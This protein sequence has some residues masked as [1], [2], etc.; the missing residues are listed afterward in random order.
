MGALGLCLVLLTA[1]ADSS[2]GLGAPPPPASTTAVAQEQFTFDLGAKLESMLG[3][4]LVGSFTQNT[5]TT[6]FVLEPGVFFQQRS[7]TGQLTISYVPWLLYTPSDSDQALVFHRILVESQQ[8]LSRTS[9]VS[10]VARLWVGDQTFSPV[11]NLGVGPN[12]GGGQAPPTTT[13][14]PVVPSLASLRLLDTSVRVGFYLLTSVQLRLDFDAGFVWS[15][16]LGATAQQVL[17]LQRGPFV[18][19]LATLKLGPHDTLVTSLR[20]GLLVYG[21]VYRPGGVNNENGS[22]VLLPHY[23]TGLEILGNEVN[24]KWQHAINST[25]STDL[26]AGM[27][28][29]YQSQSYDIPTLVDQDLLWL[30]RSPVPATVGFYPLFGASIRDNV[31]IV[32]QTLLFTGT[33]AV[34][35]II[36]QFSGTVVERVDTSAS[37][38]WGLGTN[39]LLTASVGGAGSV[40]P[41]EIDGR[42]ELRAVFQA[43]PHVV[44]AGGARLAYL[45]YAVPGAFNGTSWVLFFSVAG[46]TGKLGA[47]AGA[48]TSQG[49]QGF[50]Q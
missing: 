35:P 31:P 7:R 4:Q 20:S 13:I 17:P 43:G 22:T 42:A 41:R 11:V 34:I 50:L 24:V 28:V 44:L 32:D 9:G 49:D 14:I 26:G 19:M 33:V 10:L 1:A 45:N 2:E 47:A 5:V 12:G 30:H 40:N 3:T 8:Q 36:N 6:N 21:P 48:S 16:G 27:G 23:N 38:I 18:D 15:E 37:A 25:L 46:A 29:V 39:W